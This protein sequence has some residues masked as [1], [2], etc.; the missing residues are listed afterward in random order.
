MLFALAHFLCFRA[1]LVVVAAKMKQAVND[2]QSQLGLD[3]MAAAFGFRLRQ[4]RADDK[5]SGQS[6]RPR[7]AK[8][9]AQNIRRTIVIEIPFVEPLNGGV[10]DESQADLGLGKAF[11]LQDGANNLPHSDAIDYNKLS[12]AGNGDS[13]VCHRP[14]IIESALA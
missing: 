1:G 8:R 12:G 6:L 9:K 11:F 2:I 5:L 13:L 4:L 10:I 7:I 3:L 14:F